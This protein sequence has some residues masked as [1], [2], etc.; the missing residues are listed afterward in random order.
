MGV[1]IEAD[2]LILEKEKQYTFNVT[3]RRVRATIAA[4]ENIKCYIF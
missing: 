2:S 1:G 3:Y 4:V